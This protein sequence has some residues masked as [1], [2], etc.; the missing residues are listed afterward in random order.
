MA[1]EVVSEVSMLEINGED[2]FGKDVALKVES[3]WNRR[4]LVVIVFGRKRL[5]VN[6]ADLVNAINNATNKGL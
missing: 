2:T 3:H 4:S 6:A 1:I 5:T